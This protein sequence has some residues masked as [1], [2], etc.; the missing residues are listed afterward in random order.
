M[1][2]FNSMGSMNTESY[3]ILYHHLIFLD[4]GCGRNKLLSNVNIAQKVI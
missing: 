3:D 2:T 4:V 1:E